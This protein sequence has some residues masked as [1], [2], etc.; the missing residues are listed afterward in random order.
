MR[1]MP[2]DHFTEI[3][4]QQYCPK[5]GAAAGPTREVGEFGGGYMT[6]CQA[7]GFKDAGTIWIRDLAP[8]KGK[9]A[10]MVFLTKPPKGGKETIQ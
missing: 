2:V 1:E 9:A 7:C 10:E 5:C 6:D 4:K 3:E 8:E